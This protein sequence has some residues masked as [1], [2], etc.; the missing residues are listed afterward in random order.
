[1]YFVKV[2]ELLLDCFPFGRIEDS[3]KVPDNGWERTLV[4]IT[5]I[6][7]RGEFLLIAEL[8]TTYDNVTI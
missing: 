1:M 3:S 5:C 7:C 4:D 2:P 6:G 8:P